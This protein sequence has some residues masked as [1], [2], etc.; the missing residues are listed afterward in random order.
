MYKRWLVGGVLV[1]GVIAS[2][3]WLS[4]NQPAEPAT[5]AAVEA[6]KAPAIEAAAAPL[7]EPDFVPAPL[8]PVGPKKPTTSSLEIAAVEALFASRIEELET[9]LASAEESGDTE[10]VNDLRARIERLYQG[11]ESSVDLMQRDY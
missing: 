10:A 9:E 2:V 6:A 8:D 1:A 5:E 4:R 7:P 3:T 11:A